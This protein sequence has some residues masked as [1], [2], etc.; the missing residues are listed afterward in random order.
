[1]LLSVMMSDWNDIYAVS[2]VK[3][4]SAF[5]K[6]QS[7][8]EKSVPEQALQ[9]KTAFQD[10][11]KQTFQQEKSAVPVQKK[12]LP[13]TPQNIVPVL[14]DEKKTMR[15]LSK[16]DEKLTPFI[17][18]PSTIPGERLNDVLERTS[19]TPTKSLY[20]HDALQQSKTASPYNV[21][22]RTA[23]NRL[24]NQEKSDK[25]APEES[26]AMPMSSVRRFRGKAKQLSLGENG[27]EKSRQAVVKQ[28]AKATAL[29]NE[30]DYQNQ[31]RQQKIENGE[32]INITAGKGGKI[33]YD[34]SMAP[35]V[36]NKNN[37]A[38]ASWFPEAMTRTLDQY[39]AMVKARSQGMTVDSEI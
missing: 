17:M 6:E 19:T 29:K 13:S 22:E 21:S 38:A 31:R 37:S 35:S 24:G 8:I 11:L 26:M 32:L 18:A 23:L 30:N 3:Q 34:R 7:V 33:G 27:F 36:V 20:R 9:E 25:K 4:V 15:N 16:S 28:T 5:K 1:M 12:L 39:E 2:A 14:N 10:V